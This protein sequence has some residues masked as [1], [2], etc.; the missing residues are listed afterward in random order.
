[1]VRAEDIS[2]QF[3]VMTKKNQRQQET[4][5][6]KPNLTFQAGRRSGGTLGELGCGR[7]RRLRLAHLGRARD[8][9]GLGLGGLGGRGAVA[10][11]P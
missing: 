4:I 6:R 2:T 1:M 11:F 7:G 5:C 9:Q 8:P 3:H 10:A